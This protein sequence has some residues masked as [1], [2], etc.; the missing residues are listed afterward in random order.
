MQSNSNIIEK[1][2]IILSNIKE[3]DFKSSC[4]EKDLVISFSYPCIHRIV[5]QQ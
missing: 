5:K 2:T 4:Q 3:S 1:N